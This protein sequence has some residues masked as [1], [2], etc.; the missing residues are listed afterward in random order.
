MA[1]F[2]S[3]ALTPTCTRWMPRREE[4]W[5]FQTGDWVTSSPT[6]VDG[7]VFVGSVDT[8]TA[9]G[10][11]FV[12]DGDPVRGGCP[13]GETG[14]PGG[15]VKSSP[16]VADG[17]VFVG[18]DPAPVRGGCPDGEEQWTFQTDPDS[19]VR[20]SPTVVDDTVFIGSGDNNLYAV[21]AQ[22]GEEQWAFETGQGIDS[23]PTVADGTVFVGRH[24]QH[25]VRGGY[26]RC[27]LKRERGDR[28]RETTQENLSLKVAIQFP[29]L[30]PGRDLRT[31]EPRGTC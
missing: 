15:P 6:V 12:D 27:W 7:T 25:P 10:T 14:G 9:S 24:R 2:S 17:T 31:Q 30:N 19:T 1:Q 23:S 18:S 4:Q 5:T 22:S 29:A 26:R 11:V 13:D 28:D 3:A 21:D 8:P 16:T 20:S